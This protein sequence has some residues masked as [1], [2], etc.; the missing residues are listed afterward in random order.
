[1]KTWLLILLVAAPGRW[2]AAEPELTPPLPP[3]PISEFRGWLRLPPAQRATILAKR[4]ET[5]RRA[6]EQKIEEYSA[7]PEAE[8][9]R[10]LGAME[11]RWHLRPLMEMEPEKRATALER[12][13]ILWRPIIDVRLQQ[14]DQIRPELRKEI[15]EHEMALQLFSAPSKRQLTALGTMGAEEKSRL[16]ARISGLQA[17]TATERAILDERLGE[18]FSM[19]PR[20]QEKALHAFSESDREEMVK[21]LRDFQN[22]SPQ[23]RQACVSSFEKFAAMSQGEQLAFLRNAERWQAMSEKDRALWKEVVQAV[24]PLPPGLEATLPPA[25]P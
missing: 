3:S 6:I 24:P 18:F 10:K 13:P 14:W 15:L 9:E 23:Q 25:P 22:L 16:T 21:T 4:S 8:R 1:M 7:L 17:M 19:G 5:S 20:Q 2:R 12:V 11:L